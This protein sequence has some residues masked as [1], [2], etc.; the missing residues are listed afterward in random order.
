MARIEKALSY[1][2]E[3]GVISANK[4]SESYLIGAGT[5]R[6]E[7][8]GVVASPEKGVF[9]L[10]FPASKEVVV[11][12][13]KAERSAKRAAIKAAKVS[14]LPKIKHI[15][16]TKDCGETLC[17]HCGAEDRYVVTFETDSGEIMSAMRGCVQAMQNAHMLCEG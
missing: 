8:F 7:K 6:M 1:I 2:A 5:F 11:E 14:T 17:P 4:R 10:A 3:T 15:L 13:L 16:G 12:T 9:A